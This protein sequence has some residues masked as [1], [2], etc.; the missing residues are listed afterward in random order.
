VRVATLLLTRDVRALRTLARPRWLRRALAWI[1]FAA[2]WVV[3]ALHTSAGTVGPCTDDAPCHPDPASALTAGLLCAAAVAGFLHARAAA[4]LA[5]GF[6]GAVVGYDLLHPALESPIWV[7]VVD[8]AFVALCFAVAAVDRGRP[9]AGTAMTWLA[10]A[11]Y[12]RPPAPPRLPR[13]QARWR[14]GSVAFGLVALGLVAWY[15]SGQARMDDRQQAAT[16]VA[17]SVVAQLD[18]ITVRVRLPDGR[19]TDVDVLDARDHP[20]G[21]PL[22]LYVDAAGLRQPV[23]EP[24]DLTGLLVLA[25]LAGGAGLACGA[26][27]ADRSAGLRALFDQPQPVTQVYVRAGWRTAAIYAADARRG[28]PA[29]T[30]LRCLPMTQAL[31]DAVPADDSDDHRV[32]LLPT[33]AALLYG[34]PA[35]G[36]WCT[37]VIDGVPAAPVRPLPVTT[38]PPPF[39]EPASTGWSDPTGGQPP[40][41]AED[42]DSLDPADRDDNPYQVLTHSPHRAIGYAMTAAMP[43]V[44]VT[45]AKLLPALSYRTALVIAAVAVAL[46]CLVGWRLF[47]RSRVAWNLGGVAVVGAVGTGRFR[48]QQVDRI[49]PDRRDVTISVGFRSLVVAAPGLGGFT[50]RAA[51]QLANAL[52]YAKERA[53]QGVDPP[54][55]TTPTAPAGLYVLWLVSTPLIAWALQE[56][57]H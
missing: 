8:V 16:R 56:F 49:E 10:G 15:W 18:D 48:W 54:R 28:E 5:T 17:G 36:R 39:T 32:A 50:G 31:L 3:L 55:L 21:R 2:A 12:E 38:S 1:V 57:S 33:R 47:L 22:A 42:V 30:E 6:A 43:L 44:L 52:R 40:L 23:S 19:L 46:A 35:P 27:G 37:V 14:A 51:R 7:Y 9:A 29:I 24:Y 41:R 45:P 34:V 11:R 13:P 25:A 4:W 26:R 20:V 53:V